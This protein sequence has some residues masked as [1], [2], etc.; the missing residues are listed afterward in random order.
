MSTQV[1]NYQCPSCTGPLHFVGESGK[2]EC[3]FC[4]GAFEV[5]DIEALYEEKDEKAQESF[6]AANEKEEKAEA[7]WDTSELSE[8]WGADA[9]GMKVYNCPSCGAELITEKT[10]AATSCPY[11]DNPTIV[12]GQ[13]GGALKPDYVIPFKVNKE[14]AKEALK[15]HYRG[16]IFLPKAFSSS[17]HIDEIKGLY[18][19]FW[20]FDA[21]ADADCTFH[22]TRSITR[23]HGDYRITTVSHYNIRRAGNM[24]F[25]RIPTDA[26]K[27]MPDDYMDSIEPFNYQEMKPFSAAYLPGYFA[28]KFDV[29]SQ[30]C[31]ARADKRCRNT[32]IEIMR[33]EVNGYEMVSSTGNRVWLQRGKVHYALMPVWTLRTKWNNKEYLFMMNGQTGKFVGDLP[34]SRGKFWGLFAA[35]SVLLSGGMM[36]AD[37]GQWIASIFMN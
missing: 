15:K 16:K 29:S 34:T 27:K 32:A 23:R 14:A 12:P 36:L 6:E 10:T 35:L 33:K 30:E 31:A 22:G 25:E 28:D 24:A 19:P 7:E 3:D 11:C 20:L 1:T 8:D 18:V 9:A 5:A 2:L 13:F 4:G 26:S 17:N 21:E 37:V